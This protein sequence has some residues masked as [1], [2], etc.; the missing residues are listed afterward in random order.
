MKTSKRL[1]V[2]TLILVIILITILSFLGVYNV[3]SFKK[4]NLVKGY[5]IGMELKGKKVVRLKVD[6]TVNEV[7]YDSEGKKVD[8]KEEGKEYT[9]AQEPVNNPETLNKENY[10]KAKKIIEHR[11][12]FLEVQEY[13]LRFNEETGT[14]EIEMSN[15]ELTNYVIS[16]IL[17]KG[18]FK[19]IDDETKEIL[20]DSSFVK[21]ARVAYN[22]TE[23]GSTVVYLEIEFNKDGAKKLEELSKTYIR[24]T[25][26]VT[27]DDGTTEDKS[28]EKK[29]SIQ[30]DD[31]SIT[32]QILEGSVRNGHLYIPVSQQ[33]TTNEELQRYGLQASIYASIIQSGAVP[34]EYTI[35]QNDYILTNTNENLVSIV[36]IIALII[37]TIIFII[38]F[39]LKGIMAS[40]LQIGY[41]ALLLLVLKYTNV[42][43]TIEG[44][45][46]IVLVSIINVAF[47]YKVF[48][49]G[50]SQNAVNENLIDFLNKSIPILIIAIILCFVKFVEINSFG[51]IMFWGYVV[52][53][54]YNIVFTKGILKNI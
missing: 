22:N 18:D 26:Q 13:N 7:I 10:K 3:A 9:T 17:Q 44:L 46:A 11:L 38:I 33:L 54:L 40:V 4:D 45:F 12:N 41:V 51:M 2:T 31:N 27:K 19:M 21:N 37:E 5:Q 36:A 47:M 42:C 25:E 6:D 48:K 28:V 14:I 8:K 29:V 39:K 52:S 35:E 1:K 50:N 23:V 53:L 34:F 24:T 49:N 15:D 16:A 30:I 20:M 43:V 32:S